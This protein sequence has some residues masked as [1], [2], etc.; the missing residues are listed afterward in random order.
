MV[1]ITQQEDSNEQNG[2][3]VSE[4]R[5]RGRQS[6]RTTFRLPIHLIEALGI[7]AGQFGV[8]QKSLFDQLIENNEVL[9][10]VA[11]RVATYIPENSQRR[12]K[13]YVLSKQSLFDLERVA[14]ER[15]ISRDILVEIS[16]QRLL[17]LLLAEREKH[18]KRAKIL[19]EMEKYLRHGQELLAQ[20]EN[21]LGKAD[22]VYEMIGGMVRLGEEKMM[23]LNTIIAKG[24]ALEGVEVERFSGDVINGGLL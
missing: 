9:N 14:T 5:L 13:T 6:V 15:R 20:V 22:P 21:L 19:D 4:A 17:P 23:T 10:E 2:I 16:I 18:Y 3:E 8:K 7:I 1:S 11:K 24:K 12:S